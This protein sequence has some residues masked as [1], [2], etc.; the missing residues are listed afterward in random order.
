MNALYAL[1]EFEF[2]MAA[3]APDK[4]SFTERYEWAA[5][6]RI[7]KAPLLQH[8]GKNI[9]ESELVFFTYPSIVGD[10]AQECIETLRSMAAAVKPYRLTDALGNN[11]GKWVISEVSVKENGYLP[12][13]LPIEYE[14]KVGIKRWEN[15]L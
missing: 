2:E 7:S 13:G 12:S 6:E 9:S 14:I 8:T 4:M 10:R 3:F 1:G 15:D 5:V 11:L